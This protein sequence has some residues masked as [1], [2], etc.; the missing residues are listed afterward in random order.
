MTCQSS[1][2][3]YMVWCGKDDRT[4]P[5]RGQYCG[6]TKR[7]AEDRFTGHRDSV[8]NN[9]ERGASLPIGEHFRR[10]GHSVSDLV[11]CPVE[12][13]FGGHFVRKCRERMYINKYQLID[14]GLNRK[15]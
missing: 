8:I 12:K 2:L 3:L 7:T 15:L 14:N 6:E 4:C 11:F 1:N 9:S 13:I 10:G 5:S